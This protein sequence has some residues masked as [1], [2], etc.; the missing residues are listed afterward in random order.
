ME[1]T[2]IMGHYYKNTIRLK[3][4]EITYISIEK[5][6]SQIHVT[7]QVM[8][9]QFEGK[10]LS[11]Q[12]VG[13]LYDKLKDHDFAYAHNSYIVNLRY[14]KQITAAELELRG[15]IILSIARS[16]EKEFRA[17]FAKWLAGKYA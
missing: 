4:E 16:K 1:E 8:K 12:R 5:H 6:G 17:A 13:E 2:F 10:I 7:S 15:G 9:Y 11:K 14:V 3:P